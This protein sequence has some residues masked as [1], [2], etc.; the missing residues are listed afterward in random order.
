MIK[1]ICSIILLI[2]WMVCIFA[3][4]AQPA[5]ASSALSDKAKELVIR[6][7]EIFFP[8][9][10]DEAASPGNNGFMITLVR[11]SAHVFAY[12]LLGI[13]ALWTFSVYGVG[14]K[15]FLYAFLLCFLYAV[16][17][18]IHQIFV[19]GRAGRI[20]DVFIDSIGASLGLLRLPKKYKS[21]RKA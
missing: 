1:K 10:A 21:T 17:D 18:E 8:F 6:G 3:F 11:K 5:E 4:S 12:L 13:L 16:S 19:P 15:R 7:L 2:S 9:A 14:K 20:Y